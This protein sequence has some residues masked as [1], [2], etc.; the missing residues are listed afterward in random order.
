MEKNLKIL[1][2]A[3]IQLENYRKNQK[4]WNDL[5]YKKFNYE[6]NYYTDKN[7]LK[8]YKVIKAVQ[9]DLR[10]DDEIFLKFLFEQE[11]KK[12][13]K[14][15][16]QGINDSINLVAFL[17]SK[18]KNLENVWLF[19]KAKI[20]NF[21]TICGFDL[22][23]LVSAGLN[24]TIDYV[25]NSDNKLKKKFLSFE[26]IF[27][28][29]SEK[30]IDEWEKKKTDDYS[31]KINNNDL[32]QLAELSLIF[33]EFEEVKKFLKEW[34]NT[35]EKTEKTLDKLDSYYFQMNDIK[36]LIDI[37][38]K[39]LDYKKTD[40][41]KTY[42]LISLAELYIKDNNPI[43]AWELLNIIDSYFKKFDDWKE[44]GLGRFTMEVALDAS[45]N[46][47]DNR[48]LAL[49]IFNWVDNKFTQMKNL[50]IN[51]FEKAKIAVKLLELNDREN[52]YQKLY[53]REYKKILKMREK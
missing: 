30:S 31:S 35:Q 40:W 19:I 52:Y 14:E 5:S 22:E 37:K 29:L 46:L 42:Y 27:S 34:E 20:A 51:L 50:S 25:K 6:K 45:I 41:E 44:T 3:K 8:R 23:Y 10:Q 15:T 11:I 36:G 12:H 2:D 48:K 1:E 47:K 38:T 49:E 32:L 39:L 18:F 43:K 7:S 26:E 21:D 24:R 9:Y 53:N 28:K 13:E 33:E 17:L 16:F 4:S